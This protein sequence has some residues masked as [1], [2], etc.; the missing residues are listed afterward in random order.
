MQ[1][2]PTDSL[3]TASSELTAFGH[4]HLVGVSL[5][6]YLLSSIIFAQPSCLTCYYIEKGR[7][8]DMYNRIG[9]DNMGQSTWEGPVEGL[10]EAAGL[11][12]T[13]M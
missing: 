2:M 5:F 7:G 11:D 4:S 1:M 3:T 13:S 8:R 6:P 12:M 9:P 10:A